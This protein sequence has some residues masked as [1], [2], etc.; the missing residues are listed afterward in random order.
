MTLKAAVTAK[1]NRM[2][3]AGESCLVVAGSTAC[4]KVHARWR[5]AVMAGQTK[6]CFRTA[7]CTTGIGIG[8]DNGAQLMLAHIMTAGTVTIVDG[9]GNM[10]GILIEITIRTY[11]LPAAALRL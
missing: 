9:A 4:G 10:F 6:S 1:I 3:C 11:N 5:S 8:Q 7:P 2:G